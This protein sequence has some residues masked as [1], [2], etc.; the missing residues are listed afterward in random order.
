MHQGIG[1]ILGGV[2]ELGDLVVDVRRCRR[3]SDIGVDLAKRLDADAHRFEIGVV[4]V[5][6]DD[7]ASARDFGADQLR[8]Q[9]LPPRD[10]LHFFGD[11][12]LAAVVHLGPD[13]IVHSWGNPFTAHTSHFSAVASLRLRSVEDALLTL[14]FNAAMSPHC[15]VQGY[16]RFERMAT[17]SVSAGTRLTSSIL[18]KPKTYSTRSALKAMCCWPSMANEIGL[19]A[20]APPVWKSHSGLPVLAS[21]AKKLPS[22]EPLKTSPPAVDRTPAPGGECNRN[23]HTMR[24]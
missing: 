11:Q 3:V 22:L 6:G 18:Y 9:A 5:G 23:F 2:V 8:L 15:Y 14:G 1:G 4:D 13:D 19:A 20:M 12:A 16:Q 17:P 24:A 10:V 7:H 21:K